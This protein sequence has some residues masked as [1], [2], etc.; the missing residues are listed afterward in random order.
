MKR[1]QAIFSSQKATRLDL[2]D[3]WKKTGVSQ[4]SV[5]AY[6]DRRQAFR[7]SYNVAFLT[8]VMGCGGKGNVMEHIRIME[9]IRVW[10]LS[11]QGLTMSGIHLL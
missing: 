11:N 10:C 6:I 8:H 7:P 5:D 4:D 1:E 2:F 3:K 9:I